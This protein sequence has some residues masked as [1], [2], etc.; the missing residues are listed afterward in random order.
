MNEPLPQW[1]MFPSGRERESGRNARAKR[2]SATHRRPRSSPK[3]EL[4]MNMENWG[5][6]S[7]CR[8][9]SLFKSA[10]IIVWMDLDVMRR[11]RR[12]RFWGLASRPKPLGAD[13]HPRN[14]PNSG[15]SS[16]SRP[17]RHNTTRG[18]SRR[19]L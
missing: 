3:L 6:G 14:S 18:Q 11:M 7:R 17:S 5:T 4:S 12:G 2:H 1:R 19:F 9:N 16:G 10:L 13:M 15:T 8:V